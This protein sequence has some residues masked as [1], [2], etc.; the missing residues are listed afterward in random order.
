MSPGAKGKRNLVEKAREEPA[1]VCGRWCL[2]KMAQLSW[3]YLAGRARPVALRGHEQ[4]LRPPLLPPQ[5]TPR[6]PPALHGALWLTQCRKAPRVAEQLSPP[7][8]Y[9]AHAS[10]CPFE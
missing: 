8:L 4:S 2:F 1:R 5:G 6:L 3:S 9:K 10:S 7:I